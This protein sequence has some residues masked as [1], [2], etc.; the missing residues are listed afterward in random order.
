MSWGTMRNG[1]CLTAKILESHKTENAC[2]LW[3]VLEP[4]EK[5]PANYY[6][7]EEKTKKLLENIDLSKYEVYPNEINTFGLIDPDGFRQTNEV[8][9]VNGISTTLRT[10]R[11]GGL[12]PKVAIPRYIGHLPTPA[13][14]NNTLRIS[15][16]GSITAKHNYEHI[17]IPCLTPD[18]PEKRQ[19][20]RRFKENGEP[21]YTIT[22]QDKHGVVLKIGEN[23]V[24]HE[25]SVGEGLSYCIT[26][27]YGKGISSNSVG[28]GQ[29]THVLQQKGVVV[30][31]LNNSIINVL[32]IPWLGVTR[33]NVLGTMGISSCLT[34]GDAT[35]PKM[36]LV[37]G[38]AIRKLMPIECLRLQ[39]FPDRVYYQAVDAGI[40]NSQLYKQSGNSVT[41]SVI[42]AIASIF[43]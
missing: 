38:W 29:R 11:G 22:A 23:A 1:E 39:A 9:D 40:S 35:T 42:R 18:R 41:V 32:N 13:G 4:V 36:V 25:F 26:S 31:V 24:P 20:G 12:E 5:V 28:K 3:Q 10:F 34:A 33:G 15:G 43:K 6:L 19:N 7:S 37:R 21:M 14:T 16:K 8:L 30:P 27:S 17:A 2:S